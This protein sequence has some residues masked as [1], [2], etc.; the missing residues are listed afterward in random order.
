MGGTPL[1]SVI[2][3][4]YN[5]APYVRKC[6]D[7][8]KNQTM[9]EIEVIC[10]DD[11]STDGSGEIAEEYKS[12]EFPIFRVIH[13]ENH[14]LAAARNR[15]LDEARAEWLMF[16]DSDDWV[17]ERFCEIPWKAREEYDAD[18]VAFGAYWVKHGKVITPKKGKVPI[19][20][21]KGFNAQKYSDIAAWNKLYQ[22]VLFNEIRFPEGRV[23]EDVATTF[24]I[25]HNAR[26]VVRI[27]DYLYYYV[28]RR[29]SISHEKTAKNK[30]DGAISTWERYSSMKEFE[31]SSKD[32]RSLECSAAI[33]I[34][35]NTNEK[36]VYYAEAEGIINSM[37]E[38]PK[39]IP[40]RKK[41]AVVAWKIDKRLFHWLCEVTRR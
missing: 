41:F 38:I 15:G 4:I 26:C 13:T 19:G 6:L 21:L 7:S 12:D 10:I 35:A 24:K 22:K 14:G 16:V 17:D 40:N 23:F 18:V 9:K 37:H 3:P 8:L 36:C 1:I 34:L 20:L 25:I 32:L 33:G 5:V 2:V 31:Y 39:G 27:K 29:N 30:R 28:W 11:G